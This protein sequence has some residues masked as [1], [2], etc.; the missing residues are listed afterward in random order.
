MKYS[1]QLVTAAL[2][3]LL[4]L[5]A[6]AENSTRSGGYTLHHNAIKTDFLSPEIAKTYGIQRSR[7]RGMVNISVLK[8]TDGPVA[9]AVPAEI[10]IKAVNLM[11]VPKPVELREVRE[12]EAIYYIDDFPVTDGEIVNF[13]LRVV[14]EGSDKGITARFSQQFFID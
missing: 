13:E 3:L 7:F 4:P 11:G 9:K 14:P 6:P 5:C 10:T 12:G 2:L 8:D 1:R